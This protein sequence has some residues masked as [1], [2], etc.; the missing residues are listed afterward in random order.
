MDKRIHL[1]TQNH[2]H[3]VQ[4]KDISYCKCNNTSTTFYLQNHEPIVVSKG[5]KAVEAM[6][7]GD[8]FIRPHQSYLVNR[9]HVIRIDKSDAYNLILKNNE[10]IPTSIRKR[11]EIIQQLKLQ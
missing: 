3:F 1:V 4:I 5:I 2:I 9:A 11:K 8:N 6:L 7:Q 10:I